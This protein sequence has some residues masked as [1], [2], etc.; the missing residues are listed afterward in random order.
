VVA[1]LTNRELRRSAYCG[2]AE[3]EAGTRAWIN[4]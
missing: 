2:V 3:L 1:E 4:A